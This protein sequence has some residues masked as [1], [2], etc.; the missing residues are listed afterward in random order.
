MSENV[1]RHCYRG[2][3]QA[4]T[5]ALNEENSNVKHDFGT[6]KKSFYVCY[7][8]SQQTGRL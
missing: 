7:R 4:A 1:T 6:S 3:A 8:L 2:N 5:T